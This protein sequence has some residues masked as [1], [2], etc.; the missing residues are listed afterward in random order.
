MGR[1][2]RLAEAGGRVADAGPLGLELDEPLLELGR[3]V[4]EGAAELGELVAAADLDA[5]AEM[6]ARERVGRVG[7][8]AERAARSSVRAGT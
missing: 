8:T 1:D 7:E 5:F 2:E 3:H 4:V 6:A